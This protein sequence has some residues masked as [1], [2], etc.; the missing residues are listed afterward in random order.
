M[1]YQHNSKDMPKADVVVKTYQRCW[2]WNKIYVCWTSREM[3]ENF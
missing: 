3:Q 1:S 2:I